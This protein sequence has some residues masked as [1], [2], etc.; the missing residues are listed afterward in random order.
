MASLNTAI[1]VDGDLYEELLKINDVT[2]IKG[3]GSPGAGVDYTT[4][5]LVGSLVSSENTAE[6]EDDSGL[7]TGII[8]LIVICVVCIPMALVALY[9]SNKKKQD[10]E[11][12]ERLAEFNSRQ[13]EK[14]L[15]EARSVPREA[16]PRAVPHGDDESENESV[17]SAGSA[18]KGFDDVEGRPKAGTALAAMGVAGAAVVRSGSSADTNDKDKVRAEVVVLVKETNAPKSADELLKTYEGREDELLNHLRKMKLKLDQQAEI[19]SLVE[20]VKPGK[21]YQELSATYAGKEGELIRNLK[22][23]ESKKAL[24]SQALGDQE[25]KEKR[26]R[27]LVAATNPGKSA[28]EL[29]KSYAGRENDL[30]K[31]LEI[32]QTKQARAS[33]R[34][35]VARKEKDAKEA[36]VRSLVDTTQPGKTADEM[37]AAYAGREDELIQNLSVMQAKKASAKTPL[38][39]QEQVRSLV[40]STQPGKTVD[41][42]LAAYSGR[43]DELIKNLTMMQAKQ[44]KE[45][46]RAE[47]ATLNERLQTGKS[48]KELLDAYE[49]REEELLK[50]LKKVESKGAKKDGAAMAGAVA[51]G[52][53]AASVEKKPAVDPEKAKKQE[54][55]R[56]LVTEVQ[57]GKT[58][59]ELMTAYDGKEDDLIR[60]LEKM[61]SKKE[62]KVEK[63]GEKAKKQESIRALVSELETGKTA[64]ELMTAYDGKED[65]LIRNLEKMKSKKSKKEL[66][67]KQTSIRELVAETNPGKSAEELITAYEG[68]EDELIK[69]LE[70][71][72]KKQDK[73]KAKSA[74]K[75]DAAADDADADKRTALQ[76]QVRTLVKETSPGKSADDLLAAYEGREEELIAHLSKLK[77]SGIKVT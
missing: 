33:Q 68:K 15:A 62:R 1:N 71:M 54:S 25:A 35:L 27:V 17:H 77:T 56:A 12:A 44:T 2:P 45:T 41:E 61:K 60:N 69:N 6:E 76:E 30:I 23:M 21:S 59:E 31:N 48:T 19:K 40:E 38:D 36:Q 20:T 10:A 52:A 5:T 16:V 26:V 57:P 34:N 14:D 74:R 66:A 18:S 70:K 50:N 9:S 7:S 67:T 47:I 55:I 32:M 28:D 22:K 46:Q 49:G 63:D 72:K 65:D 24:S 29:L 53:V 3:M 8:V 64:E 73:Q 39:Q 11:R 37:L 13:A 75:L 51:A 58:A 4:N 43:E 42:L